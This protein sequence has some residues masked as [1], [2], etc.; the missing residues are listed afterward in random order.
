MSTQLDVINTLMTNTF[1]IHVKTMN[2]YLLFMRKYIEKVLSDQTNTTIYVSVDPTYLNAYTAAWPVNPRLMYVTDGFIPTNLPTNQKIIYLHHTKKIPHQTQQ[3]ELINFTA[4]NPL[5]KYI[6]VG[7]F[8]KFLPS[9]LHHEFRYH[10][11]FEVSKSRWRTWASS[12]VMRD[13]V[14]RRKVSSLYRKQNNRKKKAVNPFTVSDWCYFY[15]ILMSKGHVIRFN[16]TVFKPKKKKPTP[17]PTVNTTNNPQINAAPIIKYV[18]VNPR[19][20]KN[21][22][23]MPDG[24]VEKFSNVIAK[25]ADIIEI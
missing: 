4:Q 21:N 1:C 20:N 25:Y 22:L 15:D 18:Y 10:L 14:D 19:S 6:Y 24:S 11:H 12:Y 23:V 5:V 9:V 17:K 3:L 2:I 13:G 16:D 8:M 7:P